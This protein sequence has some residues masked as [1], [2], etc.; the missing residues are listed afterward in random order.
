M[1]CPTCSNDGHLV[2]CE[3]LGGG[4]GSGNRST[5]P[6]ERRG[7]GWMGACTEARGL[8]GSLSPPPVHLTLRA[9]PPWVDTVGRGS[10]VRS[11]GGP[12]EASRGHVILAGSLELGAWWLHAWGHRGPTS[13]QD[14]W[15]SGTLPSSC[16]Q[17]CRGPHGR[18]YSPCFLTTGISVLLLST[19]RVCFR[20]EC[21]LRLA[22]RAFRQRQW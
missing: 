22:K 9:S 4:E 17:A 7:D 16:I 12:P 19:V 20:K 15:A 5:C 14:R 21:R 2:A 1:P 6:G 10:A 3:V 13:D 18:L 11:E 8:S